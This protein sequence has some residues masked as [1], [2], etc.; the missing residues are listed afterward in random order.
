MI[1]GSFLNHMNSFH[2]LYDNHLTSL[3]ILYY[4]QLFTFAD[5]K[6]LSEVP[7]FKSAKHYLM[8]AGLLIRNMHGHIHNDHH[9][10][11]P[12]C[13]RHWEHQLYIY[14]FSSSKYRAK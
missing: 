6:N 3:W 7:P 5:L 8:Q 12:Q 4:T 1:N 10:P 9:F 11:I 13:A 14:I 2:H